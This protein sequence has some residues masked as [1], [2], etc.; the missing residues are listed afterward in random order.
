[1]IRRV[2]APLL[3]VAALVLIFYA[4]RYWFLRLW[5]GPLLDIAALRP[6]GGVVG[7]FV[8][9]T[10]FAAFDLILWAIGAFL[11]LSFLQWVVDRL[12]PSD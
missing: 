6:Q 11:L 7:Q 8:R 12:P 2:V 10:D 1:M 5:D 9:G 4:S 3:S